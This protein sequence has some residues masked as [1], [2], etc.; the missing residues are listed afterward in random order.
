[1]APTRSANDSAS[2]VTASARPPTRPTPEP[3]AADFR[4]SFGEELN[5]V[6]DV[7]KWRLGNDLAE[8]YPRIEGEV[9]EALA[10][11]DDDRRRIRT[12]IF[13][14][15]MDPA[16]APGCG[17]FKSDMNVLR[18]I[19]R[20]LLFNGGVEACDGTVQV[21]DTLPLTIYQIG[22]SLVSYA[23]NQ[24]TWQQRLFRRDLRQRGEDPVEHLFQVL[25][26]RAGRAALN[27][28]TPSDQLGELAR[29]AV[30]DYAERAIL[31]RQSNAVWRGPGASGGR[32][33]WSFPVR[34]GCAGRRGG[35]PASGRTGRRGRRPGS[36]PTTCG[37]TPRS[38]RRRRRWPGRSGRRGAG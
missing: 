31:L 27:H 26:R 10:Q 32:T 38:G 2:P 6:L 1:M 12:E 7:A 15:L 5:H 9:R 30:M 16:S 28:G 34:A 3:T 18:L 29:K 13:P 8:E 36:G 17:V 25:E 19:H 21:H 22:V 14:K 24:G 20:G 37:T 33:G 11:E 23:G 4:G 35:W